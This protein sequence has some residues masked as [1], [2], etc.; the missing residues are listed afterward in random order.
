MKAFSKIKLLTATSG[1]LSVLLTGSALAE[2]RVAAF[3]S[4]AGYSD[5][6]VKDAASA[7]SYL[8][9]RSATSMDYFELNNLCV[10]EILLKELD[11]A[12]ATCALA[13]AKA[14]TSIDLDITSLK[15]VKVVIFSNMAVAK[16]MAGDTHGAKMDLE[17]ALSLNDSDANSR[18]NYALVSANQPAT[19]IASTIGG[20]P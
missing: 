16:A 18:S 5:L 7:A 10:A 11:S 17:S 1:L 9:S 8:K 13:L 2:Y 4:T 6:M 3:G 19:D 15:E 12:S 20:A 14:A